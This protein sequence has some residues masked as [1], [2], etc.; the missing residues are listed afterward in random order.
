MKALLSED[1][2]IS[3][4][5]G[6]VEIG[7]LPPGVGVER[8]RWDGERLIDL[9]TLTRIHVRHLSGNHF[10]LH[11]V[12]LPT[13]QPVAMLYQDRARLILTDG[14]LRLKTEAEVEA[15]QLAAASQA[16]RA[17]YARQMTAI[18]SPYTPEE[19]E[20]WPIQLTEAHAWLSDNTAPTPLLTALATA[21]GITVAE[22][23]AKIQQNDAL[24]RQ[25]IGSLLGEQQKKITDL[26]GGHNNVASHS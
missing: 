12:E 13:T 8:L 6:P 9:A 11:A 20:T 5:S 3:V 25:V 7:P 22:L 17:R 21:R 1:L 26:K 16:I 23:A 4:G 10:E 14:I 24:F 19:R 15:E 18:A 2:I